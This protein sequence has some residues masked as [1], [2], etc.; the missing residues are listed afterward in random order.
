M[1]TRRVNVHA[2]ARLCVGVHGSKEIG[3][4]RS[5]DLFGARVALWFVMRCAGWWVF[6]VL[7]GVVTSSARAVADEL[8]W[9]CD[10]EQGQYQICDASQKVVSQREFIERYTKV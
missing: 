3:D 5:G 4:T 9:I 6:S 10:G 7:I 1:G 8:L 2:P